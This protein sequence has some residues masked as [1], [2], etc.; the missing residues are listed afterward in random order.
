MHGPLGR[1]RGRAGFGRLLD[2]VHLG[3]VDGL[4]QG[5]GFGQV[6]TCRHGFLLK[7]IGINV[8]KQLLAINLWQPGRA[9]GQQSVSGR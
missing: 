5:S 8:S 1:D 3:V 2:G 7:V 6:F 4:E 9:A